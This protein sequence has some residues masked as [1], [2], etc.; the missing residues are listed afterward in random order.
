MEEVSISKD[1]EDRIMQPMKARP[2]IAAAERI[3]RQRALPSLLKQADNIAGSPPRCG[4]LH[5]A[6]SI[7]NQTPEDWWAMDDISKRGDCSPHRV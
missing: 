2:P 6:T 7:W 3:T 5:F 4:G 1:R